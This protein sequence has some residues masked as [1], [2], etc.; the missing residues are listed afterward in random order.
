MVRDFHT[1]GTPIPAGCESI[2]LGTPLYC[3]RVIKLCIMAPKIVKALIG[4]HV[5]SFSVTV[6]EIHNSN[7]QLK[8]E[9]K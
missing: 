7:T 2:A 9:T 4:F 8:L 6:Y 3:S 5:F 1:D